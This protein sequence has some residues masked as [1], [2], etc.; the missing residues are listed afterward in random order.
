MARRQGRRCHMRHPVGVRPAPPPPVYKEYHYHSYDERHKDVEN[1]IKESDAERGTNLMA[2]Y[3]DIL[4][5]LTEDPYSSYWHEQLAGLMRS[6]DWWDENSDDEFSEYEVLPTAREGFEW[7]W[8]I[9][10]DE[11]RLNIALLASDDPEEVLDEDKYVVDVGPERAA[12]IQRAVRCNRATRKHKSKARAA[13]A[14]ELA[15]EGRRDGVPTYKV[16]R[17][18]ATLISQFS[19]TGSKP[20]VRHSRRD[21]KTRAM[22]G[23]TRKKGHR[24]KKGRAKKHSRKKS[25]RKKSKS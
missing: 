13:A 25:K 7:M 19:N 17:R 1:L 9:I 21:A 12:T 5:H 3:R 16:P 20:S 8:E 11:T 15:F 6:L 4:E 18:V 24:K 10:H 2:H 14:Q 22:G 23:A